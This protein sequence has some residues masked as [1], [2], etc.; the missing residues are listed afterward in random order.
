MR[1]AVRAYLFSRPGTPKSARF[2]SQV[3]RS[4]LLFFVLGFLFLLPF[5]S[6]VWLFNQKGFG[7]GHV[8]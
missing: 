8:Q 7:L 1:E 3:P 5:A 4:A 2:F 6:C